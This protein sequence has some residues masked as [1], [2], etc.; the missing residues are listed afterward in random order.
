MCPTSLA[1]K[2]SH[3][4]TGSASPEV[5]SRALVLILINIVAPESL[6]VQGEV[7]LTLCCSD[8]LGLLEVKFDGAT[9]GGRLLVAWLAVV[10]SDD[11]VLHL[12][13]VDTL[14][15]RP[16][17]LFVVAVKSGLDFAS[18]LRSCRLSESR[19]EDVL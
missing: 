4:C 1:R 5:V 11:V 18:L 8:L 10:S 7:F 14:G 9:P 19:S 12:G 13:G 6:L 3:I 17:S 15:D 16:V 2:I